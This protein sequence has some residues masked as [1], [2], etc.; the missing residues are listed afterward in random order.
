M[1]RTVPW[2]YRF[3]LYTVFFFVCSAGTLHADITGLWQNSSRFAEFTADGAVRVV[4]KDYYGFVFTPVLAARWTGDASDT[5]S[6][7]YPGVRTADL[8]PVLVINDAL[9]LRFY[10]RHDSPPAQDAASLSGFW[11]PG[12]DRADI[13]IHASDSPDDFFALHFTES[14]YARIRYWKTD[15][16]ERDIAARFT[17]ADGTAAAVPKFIR[18]AGELY[19]CITGGGTVLR[20]FEKGLYTFQDGVLTLDAEPGLQ[21]FPQHSAA[22]VVL[23]FASDSSAFGI[24]EPAYRRLHATQNLDELITEHNALRRPGR[25]P[26]VEFMELDFRWD[27]VERIRNKGRSGN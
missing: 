6:I 16:R 3:L 9:W 18:V 13:L 22:P 15:A 25:P 1:A 4:F 21:S 14:A 10:R 17:T 20:N 23:T 27:E 7:S 24:G 19:T 11:L 12:G 8:I 26:L 2:L 5:I